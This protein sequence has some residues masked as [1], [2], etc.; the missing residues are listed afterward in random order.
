[1]KWRYRSTGPSAYRVGWHRR[2]DPSAV[3]A[4]LHERS[5]QNHGQ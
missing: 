1:M 3:Q 5:V 2:S 4:W